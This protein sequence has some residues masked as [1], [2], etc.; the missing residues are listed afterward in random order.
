MKS[1]I[2]AL[3]TLVLPFGATTGR[4]IIIDGVNGLID[5]YNSSSA[6]RM[7]MLSDTAQGQIR[8][9][10]A[11][12]LG[13]GLVYALIDSTSYSGGTAGILIRG[14]IDG[15]S[16]SMATLWAPNLWRSGYQSAA[17]AAM[18]GLFYAD[19]NLA[20]EGWFSSD[21]LYAGTAFQNTGAFCGIWVDNTHFKAGLTAFE[22]AGVSMARLSAREDTGTTTQASVT[23]TEAGDVAV[24]G[25]T[26]KH[27]ADTV[28][29]L[30]NVNIETTT[31]A[32][33]TTTETVTDTVAAN[34]VSGA[35]YE[36][37]W[38][39][40]VQ[41]TTATDTLLFRIRGDNL[42]GTQ[43]AGGRLVPGTASSA[44]PMLL[45]AYFTAAAT[46]SKTFVVTGVRNAGAG[47][48]TRIGAADNQSILSVKRVG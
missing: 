21:V 17:F 30:A 23:V 32:G 28:L 26:F 38:T 3:R 29:T 13:A 42:A 15:S 37:M 7:R 24:V 36:V 14:T 41:S 2:A 10:P 46:A 5:F 39:G 47:T 6:L 22:S 44:G 48:I 19:A 31:T 8:F 33:F 43:L 12:G 40:G 18:G 35:L 16:N 9:Y 20:Q 25:A 1:A 27:G 4:R 11:A 45:R 34:L